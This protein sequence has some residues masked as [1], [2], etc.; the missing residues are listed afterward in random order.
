[1]VFL[2]A[3][4]IPSVDRMGSLQ[5]LQMATVVGSAGSCG[6]CRAAKPK[7]DCGLPLMVGALG[8]ECGS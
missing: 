8:D 7:S 6:C 1:M 2:Q 5:V 4:Q 3:S